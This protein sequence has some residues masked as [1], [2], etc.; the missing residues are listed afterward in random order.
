M[1]D[2]SLEILE[3]EKVKGLLRRHL[4]TELGAQVLSALEPGADL[5]SV[6]EELRVT[7]E[8]RRAVDQLLEVPLDPVH[9]LR[10]LLD[11]IAP[12]GA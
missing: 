3:Y 2:H 1:D 12:E 8:A 4:V 6:R 5:E 10:P 9:D 7:T 11:K